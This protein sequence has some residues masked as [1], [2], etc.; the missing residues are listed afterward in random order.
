[1]Q[2]SYLSQ[3][4]ALAALLSLAGCDP[5]T[6]AAPPSAPS[7]APQAD[8]P[9]VAKTSLD[10]AMVQ[11]QLQ[12]LS[13]ALGCAGEVGSADRLWCDAIAGWP[14]AKHTA[15]ALPD[16]DAVF[17]GLT[18][19]IVVTQNIDLGAQLPAVMG[20]RAGDKPSMELTHV[21]SRNKAH[22]NKVR[23]MRF[24]VKRA[25]GGDSRPVV[26]TDPKL[27]MY[28]TKAPQRAKFALSPH[29]SGW[30][31]EGGHRADLRKVGDSWVAVHESNTKKGEPAGVHVYVLRQVPVSDT[32]PPAQDVDLS[33]LRAR[34]ECG[35]PAHKGCAVLDGFE[36]AARPTTPGVWTGEIVSADSQA[37]PLGFALKLSGKP[38][39]FMGA[40]VALEQSATDAGKQR[41]RLVGALGALPAG[42]L[43]PAGERTR[44]L[45][46]RGGF[47]AKTNIKTLTYVRQQGQALHVVVSEPLGGERW[48]G[49]LSL[50]GK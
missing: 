49:T 44:L 28:V 19:P 37:Q 36:A 26:L 31:L 41:A 22:R 10:E 40:G 24:Q 11:T 23:G 17:V 20:L 15:A 29:A 16:Q 27:Y 35:K 5:K 39:E 8:S 3:I 50:Q 30:Q 34:L 1:M 33:A 21:S 2:T 48:F 12:R 13:K 47:G 14:Q 4:A 18:Q 43:E 7:Q 46:Q 9:P 25:F 38:D 42:K 6:P 32:L 45:A